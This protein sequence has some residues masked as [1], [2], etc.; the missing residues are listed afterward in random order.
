MQMTDA[1]RED[2]APDAIVLDEFHRCGAMQWGLGVQKLLKRFPDVPLLGLTATNIRYLDN[3]RDMASELFDSNIASEITLGEAI[4]L[5]ILP[6]PKYILSIF[7]YKD[8]LA[9]YELRARRAKSKATRDVA[10]EILEKLRR[11]LDRAEGMDLLF[12]KHMEDRHGKYLVFC[13]NAEHMRDMMTHVPEWFSKVDPNPHVYSAYS[14]DPSTDRSFAAFKADDSDHLKLLFCIDMLNEGI[15]VDDVSGVILL[16][17]T[18]SPI[19]YKQQIGRALSAR[20]S[21]KHCHCEA[22]SQTGYGNPSSLPAAGDPASDDCQC[23]PNAHEVSDSCHCEAQRAV[24]ISR[25][26]PTKTNTQELPDN[27]HCGFCILH[28]SWLHLWGSCHRSD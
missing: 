11:A 18:V 26:V 21:Q 6:A 17:P 20:P 1:D 14:E 7:K 25:V 27:C 22:S 16:R 28:Y 2:L 23:Q 19:V 4:A 24:A 5:G 12:E 8:D 13:A 9:K 3:Q 15:H 10:E